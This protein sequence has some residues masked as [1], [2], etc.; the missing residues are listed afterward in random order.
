MRLIQHPIRPGGGSRN[1]SVFSVLLAMAMLLYATLAVAANA[2]PGGLLHS[3]HNLSVGG[4]GTIRIA[5]AT[6]NSQAGE[7]C[8]FC[9]TPHTSN[10]QRSLW[11][12]AESSVVY[13]PYHSS[14]AK[15]AIGQPTGVSR[16]C[17]SCH[18]GT[19]ALG[20]VHVRGRNVAAQGG[21]LRKGRSN[22]G[23][24]LSDDHPISF[25]YTA[26]LAARDGELLPPPRSGPVHLDAN[27]EMQCTTCHDPHENNFGKFLVMDNTGSAL[28]LACHNLAGWPASV[29]SLSPNRWNNLPP[30]PWPHSDGKTVMANGCDNCHSPHSAGGS[31]RLLNAAAGEQNC[32]PCHNGNVAQK[33]LEAEFNKASVHPILKFAGM[34]DP[35]EPALAS[36]G[37]KRHVDCN[38]CHNPH[39]ASAALKPSPTGVSG[40]LCGVRGINSLGA[41]VREITYE[42]ELC[43]RCHGNTAKGP[44]R[45]SRQFPQLNL[46]LKFQD[47]GG[48]NSFHPVITAGRGGFVPSLRPPWTTAS[49]MTCCDCHNNDS[50]PGAGGKGPAGPHGS[51]YPALLERAL[52]FDDSAATT[53]NSALCFKCHNFSNDAWRDHGRH[54]GYTSCETCHDPH[55]SPNAHLINFNPAVVTGSRAYQAGAIG[56][57]TCALVCHGKE[58]ANTSY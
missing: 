4:S 36:A 32:F 18:D 20:K 17:L 13:T 2:A 9:H 8:L 29:H 22:L 25:P 31:E 50:G 58:H 27:G 46:R 43:L 6:T 24:D 16:L 23:T 48:K 42:Y 1:L 57:G 21:V 37:A 26:M 7:M 52:N 10:G 54:M 35:A 44:S 53:A 41:A 49:L 45:V 34:H 11:N 19:V 15:A 33:N 39:A 30:N 28:C 51:A 12:H 5:G 38:D 40:A 56:H 47:D 55:G 14:T 3:K